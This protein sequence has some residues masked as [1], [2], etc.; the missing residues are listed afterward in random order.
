MP[1]SV[2]GSPE[3]PRGHKRPR[4]QMSNGASSGGV[5]NNGS[6]GAGARSSP[7]DQS[8]PWA[9]AGNSGATSGGAW[10]GQ[11]LSAGAAGAAA[12]AAGGGLNGPTIHIPDSRYGY[13]SPIPPNMY[14]QVSREAITRDC[15]QEIMW[16]DIAWEVLVQIVFWKDDNRAG[17]FSEALTANL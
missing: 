10:P 17:P 13:T 12:A 16:D 1:V 15:N 8:Q 4:S 5:G 6:G 9:A 2:T 7:T 11:F 14:N 3:P